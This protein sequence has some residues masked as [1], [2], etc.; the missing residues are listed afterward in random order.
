MYLRYLSLPLVGR[1]R[2]GGR[3]VQSQASSLAPCLTTPP[4]PP[5]PPLNFR[6]L[7]AVV[8]P[9]FGNAAEIARLRRRFAEHV[10]I[11]DPVRWLVPVRNP[12]AAGADQA[13]E[14]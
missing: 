2:G 6:C 7:I 14:R 9:G 8:P 10:P 1:G 12:I 3:A 13:V 5:P 4:P 11:G